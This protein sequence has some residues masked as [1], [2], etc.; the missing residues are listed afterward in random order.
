VTK[1]HGKFFEHNGILRMGTYH[2]AML[3]RNPNL[4]SEALEDFLALRD[5]IKEICV[6][7]YEI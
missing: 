6:K 4:K 3:L 1:E 7:T 2:P 5:K